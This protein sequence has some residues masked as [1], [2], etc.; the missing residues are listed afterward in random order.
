MTRVTTT[1]GTANTLTTHARFATIANQQNATIVGLLVTFHQGTAVGAGRLR[2]IRPGAAGTGGTA[3][4]P[5]KRNPISPAAQTTAF[6]DATAITAGATAVTQVAIGGS[7]L[8]STGGW[9]ALERDLGLTMNPNAG[10]NGTAEL[11]TVCQIV[12]ASFDHT[13]EFLEG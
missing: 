11:A 10:A 6:S 1:N 5:T 4:T 2:L 13:C 7:V 9:A 3:F 12:S 8:G